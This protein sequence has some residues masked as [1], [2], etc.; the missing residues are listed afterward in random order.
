MKLNSYVKLGE[1]LDK[2]Q[3]RALIA[4]HLK[5][6]TRFIRIGRSSNRAGFSNATPVELVEGM[7]P[8]EL[9][10]QPYLLTNFRRGNFRKTL[11]TPSTLH[12][13]VGRDWPPI[14]PIVEV[15]YG[16]P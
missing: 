16:Q 12:V 5:G 3:F 8:P 4:D 13:V 1:K 6:Q 10:G 7:F 11:Y 9:R 15:L 2:R 14:K